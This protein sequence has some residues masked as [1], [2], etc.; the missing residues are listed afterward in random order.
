MRPAT[1]QTPRRLRTPPDEDSS[2]AQVPLS[3]YGA[4][5]TLQGPNIANYDDQTRAQLAR[6]AVNAELN[7]RGIAGKIYSDIHD[8]VSDWA[9]AAQPV[10][11]QYATEVNGAIYAMPGGGWQIGPAHSNGSLCGKDG[12]CGTNVSTT[13]GA[14][15]SGV[16]WGYIHTHPA[17]GGL[18]VDDINSN[19]DPSGI[20]NAAFVTLPDGRIYGW[21]KGLGIQPDGHYSPTYQ[22]LVRPP[23][24]SFGQ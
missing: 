14:P 11:G 3:V 22:Y 16:Y 6:D 15:D 7:H 23:R 5:T 2:A 10:Q 18:D 8:A 19:N 9:D 21:N 1:P 12:G 4:P 13:E 17:N 24:F 20:G